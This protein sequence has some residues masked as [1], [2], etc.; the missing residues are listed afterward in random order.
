MIT[1]SYDLGQRISQIAQ[2]KSAQTFPNWSFIE[3]K[4]IGYSD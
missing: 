3:G 2:N 1:V 4:I